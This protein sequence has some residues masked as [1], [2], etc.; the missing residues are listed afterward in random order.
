MPP[1]DK[2]GLG[3]L[4]L[5]VQNEAMLLKFLHEFYNQQDIPWVSLIWETYYQTDTPHA[6]DACRSFW[7]KDVMNFSPF[8]RGITTVE[9]K[10]GNSALFWKDCWAGP[11]FSEAYPREIGRAHV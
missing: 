9:I 5:K 11:P 3:I 4:N 7:W 1:K 10:S 6:A 2:G 8:F